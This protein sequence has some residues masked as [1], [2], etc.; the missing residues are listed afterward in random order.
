MDPF[1]PKIPL[2]INVKRA[3]TAIIL[4]ISVKRRSSGDLELVMHASHPFT[5]STPSKHHETGLAGSLA[6]SH[7]ANS[8]MP[9]WVP[10][11]FSC[12]YSIPWPS[13]LW[14]GKSAFIFS[15]LRVSKKT[16]ERG[17]VLTAEQ[18]PASV[19]C[20]CVHAMKKNIT[21]IFREPPEAFPF[22]TLSYALPPVAR[23]RN[24]SEFKNCGVLL[25]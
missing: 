9:Q 18:L 1:P 15:E 23:S 2:E 13:C 5:H 16:V 20:C 4:H 11:L 25:P 6:M 24:E 14:P 17:R 19:Y 22:E 21:D 7:N 10:E 3:K 8:E 12:M